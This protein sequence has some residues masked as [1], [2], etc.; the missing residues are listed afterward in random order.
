MKTLLLVVVGAGLCAWSS[1]VTAQAWVQTNGPYGGNIRYCAADSEGTA[2]A[3]SYPEF[4]PI[5]L[6]RSTNAGAAWTPVDIVAPATFAGPVFCAGGG[7]VLAGAAD[8]IHQ[9][10]I[11]RS[12]DNGV[13]W[14]F[15]SNTILP[16]A[17][18]AD[19][20]GGFYCTSSASFGQTGIFRST[21]RG[22]HWTSIS[23]DISILSLTSVACWKNG[24]I[25]VGS[26][27][28]TANSGA[29][30]RSTDNGVH[31]DEALSNAGGTVAALCTTDSGTI[32]AGT[33]GGGIFRST[34]DGDSWSSVNEGLQ[35]PMVNCLV[36]SRSEVVF[37]GTSD[38]IFQST[39]DGMTWNPSNS[40]VAHFIIQSIATEPQGLLLA[41]TG[42]TVYRSTDSGGSW[43]ESATGI[44][45]TSC[46]AITANLAGTVI[47]GT[48]S[49]GGVFRSTDR[50]ETWISAA[51]G[52][53]VNKRVRCVGSGQSASLFV[54]TTADSGGVAMY[55]STDQGMTWEP[56]GPHIPGLSAV[57]FANGPGGE[58]LFGTSSGDSA[59][60][61]YRSTDNG[62]TWQALHTGLSNVLF[63]ALAITPAG[64]I[65][66]GSYGDVI[67]STD[68]GTTWSDM[69]NGLAY[70]PVN[71]LASDSSG[72]VIAAQNQFGAYF[73]SGGQWLLR[74]RGVSAYDEGS[75]LC[76]IFDSA[77]NEYA[78]S[79]GHGVY[80][81]RGIW[82]PMNAGLTDSTVFAL[83]AG[84]GNVLYAATGSSGVFRYGK[85]TATSIDRIQTSSPTDFRLE[86][87]YPNP[88]NPSTSIRYTVAGDREQGTG[89]SDV[90]LVVYDMLGREVAVLVNGPEAQGSHEVS[91]DGRKLSSGVYLYR[92]TAGSSTAVRKMV[93][94]K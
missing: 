27:Y 55:R 65:Y 81:G 45:G 21:D 6:Y 26:D 29:V 51:S 30:F 33:M 38:R 32:L 7:V 10:S 56:V 91:F 43:N 11:A 85:D 71:W 88:F 76:V 9:P 2:F 16:S 61:L 34:D 52:D 62:G 87:N 36:V 68:S 84:P 72:T 28:S 17:F 1:R 54:G 12:S 42:M 59:Q 73:L 92:L 35:R 31:W 48:S 75:M 69:S 22:V 90:R 49:A 63:E 25:L 23:S 46:T 5:A 78:G 4:G 8:A 89:N 20:V 93:L 15:V 44:A 13:T 80:T 58:I 77:G 66:A 60:G 37:A 70:A 18:A 57:C 24:V 39:N 74:D 3:V 19:S 94:V 47:V 86:Q 41:G 53:L 79:E 82:A 64:T 83:C 50:G 40:G 14:T 67:V